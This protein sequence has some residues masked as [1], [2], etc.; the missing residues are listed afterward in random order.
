MT[1]ST[2]AP[3][4]DLTSDLPPG[5]TRGNRV[6]GT[7]FSGFR[8]WLCAAILIESDTEDSDAQLLILTRSH[9]DEAWK[10]VAEI[11]LSRAGKTSPTHSNPV[12][13]FAGILTE[14]DG[15]DILR[16]DVIGAGFTAAVTTSDGAEFHPSQAVESGGILLENAI[17]AYQSEGVVALARKAGSGA[18]ALW[19]P[20][21]SKSALWQEF[22]NQS[23]PAAHKGEAAAVRISEGTIWAAFGHPVS[24]FEIWSAPWNE[25]SLAWNKVLENGASK[26]AANSDV[27]ALAS[28]AG[29][30][31][32]A[33][34]ASDTQQTTLAPFHRRAFELLRIYPDGDWDLVVGTPVFTPTGLRAPL[35]AQGPG[36]DHLWNDRVLSLV[37]HGGKLFVLG[38][39]LDTLKLWHSADGE[40]WEARELADLPAMSVNN[41]TLC[42]TSLGLVLKAESANPTENQVFHL[43]LMS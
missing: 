42:S 16:I 11:G 19:R 30:C 10:S 32:A 41:A 17:V 40:A 34:G 2:S 8:H 25:N 36:F 1:P 15:T 28:F 3:W 29:A 24:G 18:P 5:L 33:T 6:I 38:R 14:A 31:Y 23:L 20:A 22:K 13:L 9:P 12:R 21:T 39:D 37:P 7:C 4:R 43:L 26:W 35:S 27:F